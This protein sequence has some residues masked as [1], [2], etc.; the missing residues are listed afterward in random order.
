MQKLIKNLPKNLDETAKNH[1]AIIRRRKVDPSAC[2]PTG[3][4]ADR[5]CRKF[6]FS[7]SPVYYSGIVA[8]SALPA[9]G[10]RQTGQVFY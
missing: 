3:R 7:N 9:T 5:K 4:P 8:T 2:P 6:V 1:G 10:R